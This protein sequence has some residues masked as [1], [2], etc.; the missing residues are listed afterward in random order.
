MSAKRDKKEEESRELEELLLTLSPLEKTILP[1]LHLG[2]LKKISAEANLDI[3]SMN[4]AFQ[5]LS[6]KKIVKLSKEKKKFVKIDINGILYKKKGLPERRL[7]DLLVEVKKISLGDAKKQ[8]GLSDNEF[9]IALGVLKEKIFA[10]IISGKIQLKATKEEA[11]KKL[12]EEKFLES[13]PLEFEKLND[14][15][16]NMFRK[17]STRK[18][19]VRID[20]STKLR[21]QITDLG[22]KVIVE[23]PKFKKELIEQLSPE[24]LRKGTWKGKQFRKYDLASNIPGTFGGRKQFYYDF[25]E[26]V[27]QKLISLG[28]KEMKGPMIVSEFWNFDALF[29]P[30]FHAAR[31]WT[32][33]YSVANKLKSLIVNKKIINEVRKMHERKW[34]YIWSREKA[35]KFILRPQ[36]TVLSAL[37]LAS[38]PSV[39]GKYFALARCY[40]PDVVDATHLTEFNQ[41]EG[42]VIGKNMNFKHLLGLLKMFAKEIIGAEEIRFIPDYYPFTEPSVELNIK[43]DGRW[44]EIGGAGI[45]RDEVVW[46]LMPE[47]REQGIKVLAWGLGIDRLAML[48]FGIRDMRELFSRK[49]EF[50]RT[51]GIK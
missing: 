38:N 25:L 7:L 32:D 23:I 27:K 18:T 49:L 8:S 46:P 17:L 2:T 13:L 45:F 10:S 9:S 41:L 29:Q 36:G 37:T 3:V 16:K 44:L 1:L 11:T 4:R 40:R 42:I 39:P 30:Q 51:I 22:K 43:K 26:D 5:F 33:T 31:E 47:A 24:I 28:F 6:N 48:K 35:M 50:L 14:E 15:Q 21:F 34:H 20:E 19:L 12:S